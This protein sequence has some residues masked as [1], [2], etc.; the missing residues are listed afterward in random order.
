MTPE[1]GA[2]VRMVMSKWGETPHWELDAIYLGSDEHGQ[3]IGAPAGTLNA[4]PGAQFVSEVDSVSLVPPGDG[5][6]VTHIATFH[7]P[8]I[9]CRVYVDITTPAWWDGDLLRAVDLDLDVIRGDTGRVWVDDEDEF[10]D[11]RVSLGY[12]DD[13]VAAALASCSR[14]HAAVAAEAPPYDGAAEAWL[15]RLGSLPRR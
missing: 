7:R 8:G 9:W 2:D 4:R 15:T 11:H 12:P 1:P 14:V 6:L 5:E 13:I 3:W 10:A